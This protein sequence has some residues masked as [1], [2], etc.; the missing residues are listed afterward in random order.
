M[1]A[2]KN[3]K[4]QQRTHGLRSMTAKRRNI[5]KISDYLL[6]FDKITIYL[7]ID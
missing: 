3:C 5:K 2:F 6:F 7:H 1:Y 4:G